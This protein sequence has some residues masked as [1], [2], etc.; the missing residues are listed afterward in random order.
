LIVATGI[1]LDFN[2]IKG[3][4]E[5]LK[6]EYVCSNY[7][8]LTVLNTWKC[9]QKL[10]NGTALFTLPTTAIKCP[11][12]PQKIVYLTDDYLRMVNIIFIHPPL[13]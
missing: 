8:P 13:C 1:E 9:I 4:N 7:S 2:Q 10:E 11:G 6:T 3:M 12:A 5:A